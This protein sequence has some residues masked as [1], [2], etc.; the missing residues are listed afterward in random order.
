MN[1]DLADKK[2]KPC[3]GGISPLEFDKID[4]LIKNI[5]NETIINYFII[6]K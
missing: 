4:S 6:L 1:C 2:C 5:K 3:E